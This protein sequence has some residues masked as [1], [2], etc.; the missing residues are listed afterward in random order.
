VLP[1]LSSL[2]ERLVRLAMLSAVSLLSGT[3]AQLLLLGASLSVSVLVS[4]NESSAGQA[5]QPHVT[6]APGKQFELCHLAIMHTCEVATSAGNE[7]L[8]AAKRKPHSKTSCSRLL[9]HSIQQAAHCK[10]GH[11][12]GST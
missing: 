11:M 2:L 6:A 7:C 12:D 5:A 8:T 4:C 10:I 1:L 9:P 3:P